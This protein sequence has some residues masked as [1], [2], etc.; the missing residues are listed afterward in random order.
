L[1]AAGDPVVIAHRGASGYLPEHTLAAYAMGYAM[2]ADYIEPDLVLTKDKHF[3]CLHDIH[4]EATTNV[5]EVFPDRRRDDGKWYAADFT[6]A[7]IKTLEAQE[8]IKGRFPQGH[9][10]LGVPT[11]EEMVELVQG[12]N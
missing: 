9:S 1:G 4:L 8:R 10:P 11:F 3:I 6:L 12:L 2:G 7:E 5:E